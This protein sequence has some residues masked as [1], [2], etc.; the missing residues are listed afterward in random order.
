MAMGLAEWVA[1][2]EH[3]KPPSEVIIGVAAVAALLFIG[4]IFL[5]AYGWRM[6]RR[7]EPKALS[8]GDR[9]R[10]ALAE[11]SALVPRI[12]PIA[13]SLDV[14]QAARAWQ[15][16]TYAMLVA[17]RRDLA[18]RFLDATDPIEERETKSLSMINHARCIMEEHTACL[19]VLIEKI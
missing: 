12:D 13:P 7:S 2:Q 8:L 19:E 4:G 3:W 15:Q 5:V 14:L 9:L 6:P 1:T 11:G 17:E 18:K 16:M 10:V